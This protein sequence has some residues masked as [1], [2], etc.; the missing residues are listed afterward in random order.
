MPDIF[1][2]NWLAALSYVRSAGVSTFM[3]KT[4]GPVPDGAYYSLGAVE[5]AKI[6]ISTLSK[7]DSKLRKLGYGFHVDIGLPG[8]QGSKTEIKLMDQLING[9]MLN[10]RIGLSDNIFIVTNLLGLHLKLMN[11]G[12]FTDFRKI[13][14]HF[15]GNITVAEFLGLFTTGPP[16]VGTPAGGDKLFT[17]QQVPIAANQQPNGL[18]LVEF[19]ASSDSLYAPFG[20]FNG[21]TYTVETVGEPGGGGRQQPRTTAL[22][23]V[24][25]VDGYETNIEKLG[26]VHS[27][28]EQPIDLKLTHMNGDV[29]LIPN[30]RIGVTPEFDDS[31]NVDKVRRLK[32][33]FEGSITD[34]SD[35]GWNSLWLP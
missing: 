22:K 31:G 27:L 25:E 7:D 24:G 16:A 23:I 29:F 17:L 19:K 34:I 10:L 3:V 11:Q 1:Q 30:D 5:S 26:L 21:G 20:D 2:G 12:P 28:L 35:T 32:L 18:S 4:G 9:Q 8:F 14:Y 13:E 15:I 6:M 33:H